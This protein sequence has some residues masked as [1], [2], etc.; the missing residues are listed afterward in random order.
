MGK[1]VFDEKTKENSSET[2][3]IGKANESSIQIIEK[4]VEV[5]VEVEKVVE[6]VI[7]VPVYVEMGAEPKEIDT[8]LND[9]FIEDLHKKIESSREELLTIVDIK[10]VSIDERLD[11][12]TE[13]LEKLSKSHDSLYKQHT[14]IRDQQS[15]NLAALKERADSFSIF[16]QDR[17]ESQRLKAEAD[18]RFL[19]DKIEKLTIALGCLVAGTIALAAITL[20]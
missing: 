8:M 14:A 11:E 13:K 5:P 10:T 15:N 7:E 16:I 1:M 4:I 12:L 17:L 19:K 18:R 2:V 20:L 9:L 3:V 6:K